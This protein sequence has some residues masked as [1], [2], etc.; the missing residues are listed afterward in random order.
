M[1]LATEYHYNKAM[2]NLQLRTYR[3]VRLEMAHK[4][5]SQYYLGH[6]DRLPLRTLQR[7]LAKL[8]QIEWLIKDLRSL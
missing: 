3:S 6:H 2:A 4:R 1:T 8:S 5:L 7:V